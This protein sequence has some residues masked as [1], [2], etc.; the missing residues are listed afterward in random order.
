[1]KIAAGQVVFDTEVPGSSRPRIA[2]FSEATE[3]PNPIHVDAAFALRCGFP[4]VIQQGP[5]TT[6]HFARLLAAAFGAERLR[7]L[8]VS[9]SAPVFPLEVLRFKAIAGETTGDR[10]RLDLTAEKTDGIV[11]ARGYAEVEAVR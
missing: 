5:M 8:D 1:M 11:T 6:A 10:V 3:D 4:D 7:V 2:L 9:F